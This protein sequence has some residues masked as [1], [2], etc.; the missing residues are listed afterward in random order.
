MEETRGGLFRE[1]FSVEL[2]GLDGSQK[3]MDLDN[4]EWLRHMEF[5]VE[6]ETAF[7]FEL[8]GDEIAATETIDDLRKL[9]AKRVGS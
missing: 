1:A 6:L 2:E 4:W 3:I 9:V 8:S 5:I 7:G